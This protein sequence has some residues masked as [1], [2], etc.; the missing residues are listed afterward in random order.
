[1]SHHARDMRRLLR[2]CRRGDDRAARS[3]YAH[4]AHTMHAYALA[5]LRDPAR[6]DDAVQAVFCK[7]M[8]L[9]MRTVRAVEDP[10]A[11]LAQLVRREALTTLRAAGR[12]RRREQATAAG[13]HAPLG[14]PPHDAAPTDDLTHHIDALPRHLREV[15]TLRHACGLTFD[16]IA[17]AANIS[18]STA[19]SRHRKALDE[20]R[21]RLAS[22][23]ELSPRRSPAPNPRS[24][25]HA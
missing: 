15:V 23:D 6:A 3:L 1:M 22:Q 8:A 11:W 14:R 2:A 4:T 19:A 18:R 13:R 12:A 21:E 24:A 25:A 9:P 5:I 16:Q 20:L 7:L 10:I 17:L